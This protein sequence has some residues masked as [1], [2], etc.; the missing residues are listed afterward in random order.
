MLA[1]KA[2]ERIVSFGNVM[3]QHAIGGEH[4]VIGLNACA[5]TALENCGAI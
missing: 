4:V 1:V 3:T 5:K 2:R